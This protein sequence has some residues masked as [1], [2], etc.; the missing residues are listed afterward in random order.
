MRSFREKTIPAATA[1]I[2]KQFGREGAQWVDR[3]LSA[4]ETAERD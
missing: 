4:I 2:E 1:F 3:F